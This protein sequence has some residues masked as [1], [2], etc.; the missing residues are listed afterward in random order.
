MR[1]IVTAEKQKQEEVRAPVAQTIPQQPEPQVQLQDNTKA[2]VTPQLVPQ[3]PPSIKSRI[4]VQHYQN[5]SEV[6]V[7]I[8]GLKDV[9]VANRSVKLEDNRAIVTLKLPDEDYI[10]EIALHSEINA[11]QSTVNH[12]TMKIELTLKKKVKNVEWPSL[13]Q[14]NA[15]AKPIGV[16]QPEKKVDP[17]KYPSSKGSVNWDALESDIKKEKEEE[18]DPLTKLFQQIYHGADEDTRRAMIK[19]FVCI[20]LCFCRLTRILFLLRIQSESGG[21]VLSTNWKEVGKE[22]VKVQAPEGMEPRVSEQRTCE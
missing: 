5:A 15:S 20:V 3:Q 10:K 14:S 19:S 6:V 7:D 2:P 8:L 22:K 21:T 12:T 1:N 13:E 11:A 18:G 9:P 4:R 17:R 16:S